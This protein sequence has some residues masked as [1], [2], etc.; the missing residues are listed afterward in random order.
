M[1]FRSAMSMQSRPVFFTILTLIIGSATAVEPANAA[2]EG[3]V[4]VSVVDAESGQPIPVRMHLKNSRG[5]PVI[6]RGT[7]SWKDHFILDGEITLKLRP[8]DYTFQVERGP[9]YKIRHGNFHI[10]SE[11]RR[12]GKECIYRWAPYH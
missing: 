6:P 1:L 11:E 10:R 5:K 9:E 2:G 12:V 3:K 8:D 4:K 7:V